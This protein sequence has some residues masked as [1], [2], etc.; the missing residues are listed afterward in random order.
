MSIGNYIKVLLNSTNE[1]SVHSPFIYLFVTQCLYNSNLSNKK[2]LSSN[3]NISKKQQ[4]LL[5]RI[6]SYLKI[7]IIFTDEL[8]LNEHY[9][10][11][12]NYCVKNH[13]SSKFDLL[14]VNH[15]N[16]NLEEYLKYMHNDSILIINNI[17]YKQNKVLWNSII[18]HPSV[19]AFIDVYWQG[20]IFI[21]KEQPKESFCIRV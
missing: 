3:I 11:S 2:K 14:F 20:Y 8:S 4:Q 15:P 9:F 13:L 16:D 5:L 7:K 19:T 18:K 1:Q 10:I 21:R 12:K 17:H 6:I